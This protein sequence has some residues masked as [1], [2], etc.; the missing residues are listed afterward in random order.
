[1][2]VFNEKTMGDEMQKREFTDR[3]Y[4]IDH[5]TPTET[6]ITQ[7]QEQSIEELEFFIDKL[8]DDL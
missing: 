5:F 7:G 4:F 6:I 3:S 2:Y 1:M 8:K